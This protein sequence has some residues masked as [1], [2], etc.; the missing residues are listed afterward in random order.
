MHMKTIVSAATL[1]IALGFGGSAFAQA[2]NLGA[3]TVTP[4]NMPQ[5][6]ARCDDLHNQANAANPGSTNDSS[7]TTSGTT[8]TGGTTTNTGT[9]GTTTGGTTTGGTTGGTTAGATASTTTNNNNEGTEQGTESGTA[10]LI[11]LD[12]ITLEQCVEAGLSTTM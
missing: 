1:T 4:E 2:V 7:A 10:G 3:Q 9:T 11:A 5:V 12:T 8:T 6:Q